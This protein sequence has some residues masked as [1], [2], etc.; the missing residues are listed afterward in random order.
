MRMIVLP[1]YDIEPPGRVALDA[2]RIVEVQVDFFSLATFL[3]LFNGP[4]DLRF[5]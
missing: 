5:E 3:T 4:R 1:V 2:Q